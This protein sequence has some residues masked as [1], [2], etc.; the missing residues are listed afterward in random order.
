[1]R[2]ALLI[3]IHQKNGSSS[4][5]C[6]KAT[7]K[8]RFAVRRNIHCT[9]PERIFTSC[10]PFLCTLFSVTFL[11]RFPGPDPASATSTTVQASLL[12]D[13]KSDCH[14]SFTTTSMYV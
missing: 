6:W 3:Q 14:Y 4:V 2:P 5:C 12:A 1:M 7:R 9:S 10:P 13:Q 8:S 11:E